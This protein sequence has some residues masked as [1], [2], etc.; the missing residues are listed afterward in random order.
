MT[1]EDGFIMA[2]S[3]NKSSDNFSIKKGNLRMSSAYLK[4]H[5]VDLFSTL[6]FGKTYLNTLRLEDFSEPVKFVIEFE[7]YRFKV[8]NSQSQ[9]LQYRPLFEI[10]DR[11]SELFHTFLENLLITHSSLFEECMKDPDLKEDYLQMKAQGRPV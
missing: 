10:F 11:N 3:K 1:S 6:Y 4:L 9:F 2:T 8:M 7:T 5:V